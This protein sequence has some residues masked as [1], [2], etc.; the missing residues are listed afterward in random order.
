VR[1]GSSFYGYIFTFFSKH[2]SH[3]KSRLFQ[4]PPPKKD[5]DILVVGRDI[6]YKAIK[7]SLACNYINGINI[8]YKVT[9]QVIS[10]KA[11]G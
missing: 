10:L 1:R 6:F 11:V 4:N 8:R 5:M 2:K 3:T 7:I 9:A